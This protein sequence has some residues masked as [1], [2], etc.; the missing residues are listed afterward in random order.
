MGLEI[1][2]SPKALDSSGRRL[3]RK[4]FGYNHKPF[5]RSKDLAGMVSYRGP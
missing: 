5:K 3:A 4:K 1:G 2:R